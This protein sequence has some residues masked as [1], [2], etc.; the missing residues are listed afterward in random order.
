VRDRLPVFPVLLVNFIGTLGFSIVLPFLVFLVTRFGGN[1]LV[2]GLVGATYPAFQLLGAPLL[3]TWSDRYGR[4]RILLLSQA[5]TL[6]SWTVF[7][8]AL[9]LP[10]KTLVSVDS[11][12]WGTFDLTLP[13]LVVF[14]ARA[15]DGLTG[16]NISVA[17]AYLADIT[18]EED[19]S[20]NFGRMG[21]SSNLGFIFGPALASLLVALGYGDTLPVFAALAISLAATVV[22]AVVLPESLPR[23]VGDCPP[24]R[25]LRRALGQEP[26]DCTRVPDSRRVGLVHVLGQPVLRKLLALYLLIFFG[27]SLFYVAFPV[28]AAA[29]LDWTIGQTGI[30][31]SVLSLMMVVVQGPLL[32]RLSRVVSERFLI[33][34]G[35][36]LLAINFLLLTAEKTGVIYVAAALFAVGNGT[37]WPSVQSVLSRVAGRSLQGAAQG[38]A[39]AAGSLASVLGLLLG[40]VLYGAVGAGTFIIAA[41]VLVL[42]T[43]LSAV[44][45]TPQRRPGQNPC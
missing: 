45:I 33:V 9:F 18:P 20:R 40:G 15:L 29:D 24:R 7:A 13:L 23:P 1:A 16:G 30:F 8:I 36:I 10:V 42:V 44:W 5:G 21:M 14:V 3:G 25:G 43:L 27:F 22:I 37:M 2:Y 34:A 31:F 41:A 17:N 28:R 11:T 35:S 39:G 32:A 38:F 4:R 26:V 12:S 6:L 19:R